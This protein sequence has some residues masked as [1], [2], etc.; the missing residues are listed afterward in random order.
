MLLELPESPN[1]SPRLPEDPSSGPVGT[2]AASATAV[3]A[4]AVVVVVVVVVDVVGHP[5]SP[6][7]QS[8]GPRHARP[9]CSAGVKTL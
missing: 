3:A 1:Q 7:W 5:P 8:L 6:G 4:A 9:S 2:T